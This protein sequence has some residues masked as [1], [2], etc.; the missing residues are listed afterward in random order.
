M[1]VPEK[2]T[3]VSAMCLELTSSARKPFF[4]GKKIYIYIYIYIYIW[5]YHLAVQ[6]WYN[7]SA[8]QGEERRLEPQEVTL[9]KGIVT[10][11]CHWLPHE[12]QIWIKPATG[13]YQQG[14]NDVQPVLE[15]LRDPDL[16]SFSGEM[17]AYLLSTRV[18][19]D[20][21]EKFPCG[22]KF[23]VSLVLNKTLDYE[24][25]RKVSMPQA[26]IS[27]VSLLLSVFGV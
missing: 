18:M 12:I 10:L 1:P 21:S 26:E 20:L 6:I 5:A 13:P 4:R 22:L 14:H 7:S 17:T 3:I 19:W 9:V 2:L 23:E 15:F 8:S 24:V 11:P 16:K 27:L 25:M